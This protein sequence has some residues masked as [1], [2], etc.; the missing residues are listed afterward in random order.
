MNHL[1]NLVQIKLDI[2]KNDLTLNPE[3]INFLS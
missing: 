1:S 3:N 2:K